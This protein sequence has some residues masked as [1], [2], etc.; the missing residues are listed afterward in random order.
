MKRDKKRKK[1]KK[2]YFVDLVS[3]QSSLLIVFSF[4]N[5]FIKLDILIS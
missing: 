2:T 3:V 5:E 1:K 4:L